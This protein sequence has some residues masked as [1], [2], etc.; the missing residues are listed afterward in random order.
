MSA[1]SKEGKLF[2]KYQ[3]ALIAEFGREALDSSQVNKVGRRE[4]G[5]HWG[6]C[7]PSDWTKIK[8]NMYYVFNT[9]PSTKPGEHWLGGIS[10]NSNFYL[11]DSYARDAP[12]LVRNLT[13]TIQKA[14]YVIPPQDHKKYMEQIGYTSQVCGDDSLAWLLVARD[15]G[16]RAAARLI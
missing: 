8:P 13:K 6:G 9:D 1:R 3:A 16:I 14:G 2:R 4:F 7:H 12:K 10:T 11:Y 5:S 15:M